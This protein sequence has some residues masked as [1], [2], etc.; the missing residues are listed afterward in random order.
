MAK[1]DLKPSDVT[2]EHL[3]LNRRNFISTS[4]YAASGLAT[5][6]LYRHFR[7]SP[8]VPAP[9]TSVANPI[10]PTSTASVATTA[11][12][13]IKKIAAEKS[14]PFEY[15]SGYNNYYEFSTNK[16]AVAEEAK[17]WQINDW[18]LEIGGLVESAKK[19]N[20]AD[21]RKLPTED[22]I[23]R[24]RCVEGWSMV[25]PWRGI[26]LAALLEKVKPTTAAKYVAF[27]TFYDESAMP[28][29]KYSG[30]QLPYVE[31]LRLD[32][33][34]HPL[35]L[36]A[37]GLYGK[38]LPNQNGAPLRLVV[39]W[40]YGF[41]SIKS[42]TK[43]TLTDVEPPTTWNIA[44]P[45]EYGFYSNVNPE[46]DHPRWSQSH[47][48]RIGESGLRE[49]LMFNGYSDQVGKLYAGLDLRKNF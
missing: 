4:I 25:I 40:K 20:L 17:S 33:A 1:N 14:T 15:I 43:I 27:E 37:T 39:P 47:E 34:L 8:I 36:I 42:V 49:T 45:I 24:F 41:K 21:I 11:A 29:A 30:I 48:R 38:N 35:T 46:V 28:K 7:G 19:F 13:E 32:E 22:R 16:E 31:G 2:S 26:P 18:S 10:A 9:V 12:T 6:G 44:N 3:Y 5:Y 23:Y